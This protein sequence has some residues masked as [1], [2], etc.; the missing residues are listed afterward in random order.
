MND[1]FLIVCEALVGVGF[2]GIENFVQRSTVPVKDILNTTGANTVYEESH[3]SFMIP[4]RQA[5]KNIVGP[6]FNTISVPPSSSWILMEKILNCS[7][8]IPVVAHSA[9][10]RFHVVC[11]DEELI[12]SLQKTALA[13]GGNYPVTWNRMGKDGI[14]CLFSEA[15]RNIARSLKRE[16][17]PRNILN[18][19]L[20]ML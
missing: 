16:L 14:S 18:P 2:E 20:K 9:I 10:G 13:I 3:S 1:S 7:D 17:D 8:H 4:R 11:R 6:G 15:E 5:S 12:S 19:H